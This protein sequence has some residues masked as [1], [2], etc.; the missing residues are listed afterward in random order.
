MANPKIYK[1]DHPVF[2]GGKYYPANE[3]FVTDEKPG[4]KW[5]V[6]SAAEKA[7]D[8]AARGDGEPPLEALTVSE[9]R[10]VAVTKGVNPDGLKKPDIIS[11]IAAADEPAL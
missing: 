10:A 6:V 4:D 2:V 8:D 11:A 9:L 5:Q 1:A 7:A 3:P